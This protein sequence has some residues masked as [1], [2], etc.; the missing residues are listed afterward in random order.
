MDEHEGAD[1][2]AERQDK[3]ARSEQ[4]LSLLHGPELRDGGREAREGRYYAEGEDHKPAL[5]AHQGLAADGGLVGS[6]HGAHGQGDVGPRADVPR[7]QKACGSMPACGQGEIAER[8]D[9]DA[10]DEFRSCRE[11]AKTSPPSEGV[12]ASG[13]AWLA[14][15]CGRTAEGEAPEVHP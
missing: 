2:R 15:E 5:V 4:V 12:R 14:P 9:R 10:E 3:V 11:M 7:D 1:D 8:H 13:L 6:R